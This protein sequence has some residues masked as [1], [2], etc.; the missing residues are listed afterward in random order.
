VAENKAVHFVGI[1]GVGMS[2]L[3]LMLLAK[4]ESVSGSDIKESA[5]TRTLAEKGAKIFTGHRA[6]NVA[7][8]R[9]LVV[10]SAVSPS[11]PELKEAKEKGI[12]VIRRADMLFSLMKDRKRIVI[13]G[14]H[15]KTTTTSMIAYILHRAGFEPDFAVGGYVGVLGGVNAGLGKGEYF[16]AEADESDGSFLK[17][18]PDI[19][20]VTNIEEEHLDH[21][22]NLRNLKKAF[23]DFASLTPAGGIMIL[24]SDD[25]NVSEIIK[26]KRLLKC[27]VLTYS[28]SGKADFCASGI[29]L[30]LWGSEFEVTGEG[31]RLGR[32]RL[33]VPGMHNVANALAAAC[34]ALQAGVDFSK[35]CE[36][37]ADFRS[38]KR[39]IEVKGEE[40][41]VLV[42]DDYAHHP[43]EID[44]TMRVARRL[45]RKRMIV[46]FQPHRYSRTRF[47]GREL[48]RS[49]SRTD[50]VI[51]T[52]IYSAGEKEIKG[53]D[54]SVIFS[55]IRTCGE[56]RYIEDKGEAASYIAGI[57]KPGD[58]VLTMG[59]GDVYTIGEEILRKLKEK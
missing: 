23:W 49:L 15:G 27:G 57:A 21:Y 20:I 1:G 46:V 12:P 31:R 52:K 37:L 5:A 39:R 14:T 7:D 3:A 22:G 30:D 24:N 19:G 38:A 34:A 13:T 17:L 18:P 33:G 59:A 47:L 10:S 40:K 45:G 44:A 55:G 56:K 42:I 25:R 53:V 50:I 35:A 26:R 32:I 41:G 2:G 9:L 16:V 58:L 36:A 29:R 6:Q 28:T 43:S 51:L 48:G 11:N 8:A 54:Q 4:G